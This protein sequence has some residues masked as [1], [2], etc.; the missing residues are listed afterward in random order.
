M[1]P[2][3]GLRTEA[4]VVVAAAAAAQRDVM[5]ARLLVGGKASGTTAQTRQQARLETSDV[6]RPTKRWC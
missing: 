1:R 2:P 6:L 4:I 3:L 5:T